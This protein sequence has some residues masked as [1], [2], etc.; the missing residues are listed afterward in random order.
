M[1]RDRGLTVE[2]LDVQDV[3]DEFGAGV[4]SPDAIRDFI[5]YAVHNWE[6]PAPRFVLLVGDASWDTKNSTVDDANYANWG[7]RESWRGERFGT[8]QTADYAE[9]LL[10]NRNLIPSWNYHTSEGHAASDAYFVMVEGDDDLPDLA[11]GRLPVVEPG[12]VSAITAKVRRYIEEAPLGPWRGRHLWITGGV[13][14][15]QYRSRTLAADFALAGIHPQLI[16][17]GEIATTEDRGRILT[18]LND[19]TLLTHFIGHG[20]R[21]IWRTAPP[22][23]SDQIDLFGLEELDSLEPSVRLPVVLSVACYSAPFDHPSADSIG[24]AFLRL[25]D[26][27]AIGFIGASWRNAPPRA[28]SELLVEALSRPGTVGEALLFAKRA[29]ARPD[30]VHLYNLLGDPAVPVAA[31]RSVVAVRDESSDGQLVL[32]ADLPPDAVGGRA[33]LAF[34]DEQGETVATDEVAIDSSDLRYRR[35]M[36]GSISR[37]TLYFWNDETGADGRGATAISTADRESLSTP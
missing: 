4:V 31:P 16:L 26:R 3:Y 15:H 18:A 2:V 27:G 17:P 25:P 7:S 34:L 1:H 32:R 36:E 35:P 14:S 29:L 28:L 5:S 13:A 33:A 20:G 11:L 8:M 10:N 24:E 37:V 21:F 22:D 9:A 23:L 30:A 19:G 12:E 6:A